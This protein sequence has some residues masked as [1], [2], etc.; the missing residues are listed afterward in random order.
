MAFPIQIALAIFF[1]KGNHSYFLIYKPQNFPAY[2]NK[3][4]FIYIHVPHSNVLV[5]DRPH[6]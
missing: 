6:K 4:K 3:Y 2:L 1:H 5:N